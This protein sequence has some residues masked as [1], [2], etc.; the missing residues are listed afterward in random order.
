MSTRIKCPK[1]GHEFPL[2]DAVSEEYKK[3]LREQMLAYKRQKD[4]ELNRKEQEWR[5]RQQS[6]EKELK[7]L[8]ENLR[9]SISLDYENQLRL[10]ELG[11]RI[12]SALE[13]GSSKPIPRFQ[14]LLHGLGTLRLWMGV[15]K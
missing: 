14:R 12:I 2:A 8:E 3:D 6:R 11:H 15:Q 4:E 9:K 7:N 5:E 13:F 1:C 10:F